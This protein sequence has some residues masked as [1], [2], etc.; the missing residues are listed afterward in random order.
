[1]DTPVPAGSQPMYG[2]DITLNEV[3]KINAFL[4]K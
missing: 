3:A 2:E 4:A 1:M